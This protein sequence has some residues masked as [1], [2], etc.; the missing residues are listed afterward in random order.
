VQ[1]ELLPLRC[2][3]EL[4]VKRVEDGKKERLLRASLPVSRVEEELEDLEESGD[5]SKTHGA[6]R[7]ELPAEFQTPRDRFDQSVFKL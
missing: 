5:V 7:L 4:A 1:T 3:V 2:G 6:D